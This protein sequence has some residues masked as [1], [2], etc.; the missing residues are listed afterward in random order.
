[1]A[2]RKWPLSHGLWARDITKRIPKNTKKHL[3]QFIDSLLEDID[4]PSNREKVLIVLTV[5]LIICCHRYLLQLLAGEDPGSRD[6]L[7]AAM[8]RVE[9]N[10]SAV[11]IKRR[12][13]KK[14]LDL[15]DIYDQK[16]RELKR[17]GSSSQ[18][19]HPQPS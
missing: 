11:G 8:G 10:L 9:R 12:T 17:V 5:P 3:Y 4:D 6:Y 18:P 7:L 15:N 16:K 14:I 19:H 13:I 1:M 2:K